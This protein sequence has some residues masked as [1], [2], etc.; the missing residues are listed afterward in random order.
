MQT[1]GW[2]QP[3]IKEPDL[4]VTSHF[5]VLFPE[6]DQS[7]IC[8]IFLA[9]ILASPSCLGKGCEDRETDGNSFHIGLAATRG[10][11]NQ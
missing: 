7:C 3:Q 4:R 5:L 6:Y 2:G 1:R 11:G 10:F 8:P 9:P